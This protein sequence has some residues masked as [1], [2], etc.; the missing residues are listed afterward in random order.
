MY[1]LFSLVFG[2][3]IN[4]PA[5]ANTFDI[6]STL[7]LVAALG[8]ALRDIA[9]KLVRESSSTM[10]LSFY[11]CFLFI[12]SGSILLLIK[13]V[14]SFPDWGNVAILTAMTIAGCLGFSL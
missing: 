9:T 1:Q 13:G 8:M 3:F 14:P 5:G 4:H 12:F 7:V 10:L 11:S 6:A 2:N